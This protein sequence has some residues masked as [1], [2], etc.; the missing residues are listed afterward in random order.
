VGDLDPAIR[1]GLVS[2]LQDRTPDA[3]VHV[4]LPGRGR[5]APEALLHLYDG[6][7]REQVGKPRRRGSRSPG[8]VLARTLAEPKAVTTDGAA[9]C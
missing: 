5:M 6:W 3:G 2:A 4:L 7:I 9:V 1:S 8:I